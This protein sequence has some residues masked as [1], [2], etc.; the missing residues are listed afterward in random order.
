MKRLHLLLLVLQVPIDMLML[1]LASVSAYQLRFTPMITD[2]RPVI[3]DLSFAEFLSVASYGILGWII[4]FAFLGLYATRQ[5]KK[6]SQIVS[7]IFVGSTIGLAGVAV[8]MLFTQQQFDSRFLVLAAW[9]FSIIF[10][11]FGR[12]F[13]RGV[14]AILYR[15]G[16][17]L[18]R[19][20]V[21]G[22]GDI[23]N[24]IVDTLQKRKE[25]GY[26]VVAQYKDFSKKTEQA[27]LK[28]S[29][30]ELLFTNPRADEK[31]T[32]R[33]IAFAN[34]H[35]ITFR[36]SADLFATYATNMSVHPLAGIPVVELRRTPLEGWGRIA[37]RI[38]DIIVSLVVIILTSPVT[39]VSALIILLETG[40]PIIYKNERVGIRGRRFFTFKFR[41]MYQKDSTGAQFGEEGKK[42]EQ[43]EAELIKKKSTRKGPIYKIKDDPRVT[44]FGRFIRRWSIDELPQFFNVLGGSMSV[45]GPRPHQPREVEKYEDDFPQV[46]TLKPG[47]T[48]L[49]QISGRSDLS[50]EEEMRL[51]VLYT[52][53]W[54]LMLDLII[55]LK[56]PF[57]LFRRRKAL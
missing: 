32:L 2:W 44:K 10:V 1:F 27:T 53:K 5:E 43:K 8:Y 34:T 23:A 41:S 45:V 56:T 30:D 21:I 54:T 36:Y 24:S 31:Q 39:L 38:L 20:V 19:V 7:R 57:I 6:M 9:A 26:A 16:I 46:F 11:T 51:D 37:K 3:F 12:L 35:H 14:K 28:E 55:M 40:L 48:G 15:A 50:F 22:S 33:A 49:A 4:I 25:L 47:I 29:V 18:R 17:G 42:A 13:M 52:E